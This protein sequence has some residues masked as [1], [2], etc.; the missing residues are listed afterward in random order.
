MRYS[1]LRRDEKDLLGVS[2]KVEWKRAL[3]RKGI[4]ESVPSECMLHELERKF[5]EWIEG[6]QDRFD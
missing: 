1:T 2:R 3:G 6:I 4:D 5:V